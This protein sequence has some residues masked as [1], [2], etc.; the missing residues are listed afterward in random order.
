MIAKTPSPP[1]FAVIFTSIR[2][3]I[4]TG[5][6]D[7]AELMVRLANQQDGFLGVE[8]A[9][10]DVG[11]TVSYWRDLESIRKWKLNTEHLLAQDKGKAQWYK[12]YKIRICLVERDYQFDKI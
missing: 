2:T 1:Y 3:E 10:N 7:T 6:A 9:R 8:S 4:E 5:Y 12:H 11:I